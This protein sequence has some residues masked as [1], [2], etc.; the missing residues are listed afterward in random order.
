MRQVEHDTNSDCANSARGIKVELRAIFTEGMLRLRPTIFTQ[1]L[2]EN[3]KLFGATRPRFRFR[4]CRRAAK[5]ISKY[6]AF[7]LL[8]NRIIEQIAV[9]SEY[10]DRT[11]DT[12]CDCLLAGQILD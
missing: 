6:D 8:N 4:R 1:E 10:A 9:R 2:C 12:I 5:T 3:A 11:S 7:R